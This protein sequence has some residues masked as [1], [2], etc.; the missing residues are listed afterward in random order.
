MTTELSKYHQSMPRV[1]STII[2]WLISLIGEAR[3]AR[4]SEV[5]L[6]DPFLPSTMYQ[7]RT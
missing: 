7:G 3:R 2:D 6:P 5:V 1:S 4:A